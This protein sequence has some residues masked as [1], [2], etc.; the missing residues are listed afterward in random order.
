[1]YIQELTI[2]TQK[3]SEQKAFYST[4]LELPIVA[5][6]ATSFTVQAGTTRLTLLQ[7]QQ[8][9]LY[10]M[11]FTIPRNKF[12]Q[13]KDWIAQRIPLLPLKTGEDE[14]FFSGLDA[15][16]FYFGDADNNILEYMVHNG[17]E[18]ETPGAFG[19]QDV[20]RVS[21]IGL[22]V[23]DVPAMAT[24]LEQQQGIVSYPAPNQISSDFAYLGD[25]FGQLVVVKTGRPWL[26]TETV[27]AIVSPVQAVISGQREE[28]IQSSFYPYTITVHAA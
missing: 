23:E 7:T 25:I 6:T 14:I 22:P 26:P 8:E 11:A 12:Q 4:V 2:Q 15:R 5:E 27:T 13:A 17:L 10:H 19:P 20:L 28:Q 18:H 9:V 21:E 16:S 3:L 1:M 24:Q